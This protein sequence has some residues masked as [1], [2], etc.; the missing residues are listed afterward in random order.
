MELLHLITFFGLLL[1]QNAN[2]PQGVQLPGLL[3]KQDFL[4]SFSPLL[5]NDKGFLL[6]TLK[7]RAG[8]GEVNAIGRT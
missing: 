6:G 7:I 4:P 5:P 2:S 8:K 3:K 1:G